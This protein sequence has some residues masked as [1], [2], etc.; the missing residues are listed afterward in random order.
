MRL[1]WVIILSL[2]LSACGLL[3]QRPGT[4]TLGPIEAYAVQT[5]KL[6]PLAIAVLAP[7]FQGHEDA[8]EAI[9]VQVLSP[10]AARATLEAGLPAITV[11]GSTWVVIPGLLDANGT[12]RG[13]TFSWTQPRG[14]GLWAH[15]AWHIK[16]FRDAPLAFVLEG[17][18]GICLSLAHGELYDHDYV[19][20][21]KEA[22]AFERMVRATL[23]GQQS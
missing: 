17:L 16:Q 21:E 13:R 22:I 7:F 11:L 2:C 4:P 14:V 15:E 8:L 10:L 23:E 3:L 1:L 5:G 18:K 6:A 20:Y 19:P 9:R 12:V